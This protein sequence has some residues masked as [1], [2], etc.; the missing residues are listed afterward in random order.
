MR[1]FDWYLIYVQSNTFYIQ[2]DC[3]AP[4]PLP[5]GKQPQCVAE[6]NEDGVFSF[7]SLPPGQYTVVSKG[8]F[9]KEFNKKSRNKFPSVFYLHYILHV[10]LHFHTRVYTTLPFS[11]ILYLCRFLT[12]VTS[13]LYL[14]FILHNSVSTSPMIP[15]FFRYTCIC[16]HLYIHCT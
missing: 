1:F 15:L 7:P 12:I 8:A 16:T 3:V 14:R 11:P 4:S 10:C 13:R 2:L 9:I 6:S 5:N